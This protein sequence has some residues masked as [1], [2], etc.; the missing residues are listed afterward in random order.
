MHAADS[1]TADLV[2]DKLAK[3]QLTSDLL[4]I[5]RLNGSRTMSIARSDSLELGDYFLAQLAEGKKGAAAIEAT[6]WAFSPWLVLQAQQLHLFAASPT[7]VR[8]AS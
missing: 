3:Q 6:P 7:A 8:R 1:I 5:E 4:G 2:G